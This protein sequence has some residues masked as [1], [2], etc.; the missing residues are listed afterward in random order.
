MKAMA[1]EDHQH[2]TRGQR[3][4]AEQGRAGSSGSPTRVSQKAKATKPSTERTMNAQVRPSPQ[5]QAAPALMS[6]R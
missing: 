5:P 6:P 4:G 1:I 2:H 3:D